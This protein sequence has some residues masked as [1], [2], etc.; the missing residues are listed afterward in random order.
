[1]VLQYKTDT[2]YK[3]TWQWGGLASTTPFN[4]D[5]NTDIG[6]QIYAPFGLGLVTSYPIYQDKQFIP[7][8]WKNVKIG[9]GFLRNL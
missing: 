9:I 1:M 8:F 7:S 4:T 5:R 3:N 6:F 2:L